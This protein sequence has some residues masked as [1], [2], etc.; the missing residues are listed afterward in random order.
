MHKSRKILFIVISSIIII[1][2]VM[3]LF[4]SPI[5]KYLIQKYDE[6]YT[7]RKITIGW[8]YVNPFTGYI[9]LT[10]LKIYEFKSDSVFISMKGLSANINLLKLLS[11]TLKIS[12]L[13][14]DQPVVRI[15]Q[16]KNDFNFNDFK[17]T[18][19][20][21]ES[22][23]KTKKPFHYY[24]L[25]VEIKEGHFYYTDEVIP[26][27]YSIKNVDIKSKDGW[28]W[29]KD[30]IS[31]NFSFLS[32]IGTG[33]MKGIFGM[34]LKNLLYKLDVIVNNFDMNVIEQYLKQ[35]AN[36]GSF[37]A[38]LDADV[39]TNGS[40]RDAENI[41]I[42]GALSINDFHFGKNIAEDYVSFDTL[43]FKMD[44][45]NPESR[46]YFI[47]SVL[48]IHPYFKYETYDYG[49]DNAQ[50]MFGKSG[51]KASAA[52]SDNAQFNLIFTIG[53]YIKKLAKNFFQSYYKINH[54]EIFKGDIN[55]CDYSL[56][57]KFELEL[58]PFTIIADSVDKNKNRASVSLESRIKPYGNVSVML[59]INPKDTGYFDLNYHF[60]KIPIS[61]FNPYTISYTSFP[62]DRGTIELN[63]TWNVRN[64]L[65]Q[66]VNHLVII[67][68]RVTKRLK[69][70]DNNWIPVPL[71]MAFVR[72]SGNV[73][74]YEIPITGNF[75]NPKF[76]LQDVVFDLLRNIFVKPPTTPY[77]F[78]VKNAETEIEKSLTLKWKM[79]QCSILPTQEKFVEKMADFL[80]KNPKAS[81][82]VYPKQYALKEKEYILFFEAKKKYF[83]LTH[84]NN[85][86]SFKKE[87]S[88]EVDKMSVKD[89]L[90]VHYL[91]NKIKDSLIF[92]IQDKCEM[93]IDSVIINAKFEQL[94]KERKNAFI[95]YFKER[96]V[97]KRVKISASEDVIPYNGFSY[98]KIEYEG[99]FPESLIK[100]YRKMSELNDEAPR[101]IFEEEHT[102]NG[103]KL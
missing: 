54:L 12:N 10:N 69:N 7:G 60:Q 57:E 22:G 82:T 101:K 100:A 102:K 72:E 55:F 96:Q 87:D 86:R 81:I 88:L 34:N 6:K 23:G 75:K 25:N 66:S 9:H 62:L 11:K 43:V 76:H 30:T 64:S 63:G 8:A 56:S 27:N 58:N 93:L 45:V 79:R 61:I 48:L 20:S 85:A 33:G 103:S 28:R 15:I 39:K 90:F 67:D 16:R 5:T 91:N 50:T 40:F 13:T 74:D 77:R 70:K 17:G 2:V 42:K 3:F 49:L 36:Y 71:I 99:E 98:Y 59:T 68:P 51:V 4:I 53:K 78:Q 80:V 32:E 18:F 95:F 38:N 14:F 31:A 84:N 24:F 29:D 65:I 73:I 92:T 26:A 52:L 94:I 89:S 41:N 47:D 35:F 1:A 37:R 21:K 83:L 46:K 97:E 44:D 19:S